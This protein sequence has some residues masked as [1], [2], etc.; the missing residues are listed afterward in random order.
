MGK[1]H[2]FTQVLA[3]LASKNRLLNILYQRKLKHDKQ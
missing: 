2:F 1:A 3:Y